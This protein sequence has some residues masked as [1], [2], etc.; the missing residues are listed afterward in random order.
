[1]NNDRYKMIPDYKVTA[2]VQILAERLD[3]NHSLMNIPEMWKTTRGAGIKI[4]V[5]D[6]GLPNHVDIQPCGGAS[7]VPGYKQ[8]RNGHS[9]HCAGIIA[10]IA[11]NGMGCAGIAPDVEDY[12]GAVLDGDGS[13]TIEAIVKGI[14]WAVDE[15]KADIISMSLGIS[16]GAPHIKELEDACK[17]AVSK[18]TAV[19]AA[20]G[21]EAG[22][23]G[24]PAKYDCVIAVAAVND[25]KEHARFSNVGPEV[26]F[27]AGGVDVYSTYLNNGYAKLSGTSMACPALAAV[28]ALILADHKACGEILTPQ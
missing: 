21:N 4:A 13:G 15:I 8:D 7:F 22:R 18:G 28:G 20:A 17:Y 24:Q 1:M 19:F 2:R 3:F 25:R 9:T 11:G 6:T 10:A 5:L 12:Y 14:Y 26:D 23:V 27:A 16:D